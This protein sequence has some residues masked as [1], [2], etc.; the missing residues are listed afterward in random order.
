MS[1]EA[2][3][4][5]DW[6]TPHVLI[7]IF[8]LLVAAMLRAMLGWSA[9]LH[10]WIALAAFVI[11]ALAAHAAWHAGVCAWRRQW[12]GAL[13]GA[14]LACALGATAAGMMRLGWAHHAVGGELFEEESARVP[15]RGP[16][17]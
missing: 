8:G 7:A 11:A 15:Q 3:A 2:Q 1:R 14:G 5:Q 13:L 4:D 17:P 12:R 16:R 9:P 10:A 6:W